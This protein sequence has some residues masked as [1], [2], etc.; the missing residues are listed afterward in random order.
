MVKAPGEA[1]VEMGV[2][3]GE[4]E[5]VGVGEGPGVTVGRPGEDDDTATGWQGP[6]VD[7]GVGQRRAVELRG[8]S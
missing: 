5:A 3:A 6:A 7:L 2:A 1:Q 4:V 8:A